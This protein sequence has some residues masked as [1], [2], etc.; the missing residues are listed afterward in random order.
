MGPC[1]SFGAVTLGLAPG[2]DM[3]ESSN[4]R[5]VALGDG[6]DEF[7]SREGLFLAGRRDLAVLRTGEIA[8]LLSEAVSNQIV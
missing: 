3:V 6:E 7:E 4:R 2:L 8:A 5:R 1:L